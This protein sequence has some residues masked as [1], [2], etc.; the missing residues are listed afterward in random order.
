MDLLELRVIDVAHAVGGD[1]QADSGAGTWKRH[2]C[3]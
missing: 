2:R 1:T 3:D